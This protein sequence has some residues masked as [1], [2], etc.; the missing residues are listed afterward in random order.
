MVE[1][2]PDFEFKDGLYLSFQD[3]K[4]N[5]PIPITHIVSEFDIRLPDYLD[6]VLEDDTVT[7][8]DNL[9]EERS[10]AIEDLWGY[11][12]RGKVFIAFGE[13]GS[14]NNPEFFSFYPLL[15]IGAV[16]FFSGVEAY[17]RTMNAGPNMGVGFADPMMN[18]TMTVTETG[19]VQLLLE[20]KTGKILLVGRGELGSAPIGLVQQVLAPDVV[21]ATEFNALTQREQKQKGMFYLRK[22]NERN[23][24]YFP[25]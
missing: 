2:T 14:F 15:S 23:P 10:T 16:S 24:I 13:E 18:N 8:Y 5:N 25:Q 11:A 3:F 4:N 22:F 7:Y 1:Y 9:F 6:R 21:L 17:Y 20:F 19:Q 12:Q